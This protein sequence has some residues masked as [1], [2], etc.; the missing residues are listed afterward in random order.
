MQKTPYV[1]PILGGR[2]IEHLKQNIEALGLELSR[3][4][5]DE[6]NEAT[7]FDVGFPMNMIFMG[8]KYDVNLTSS[9]VA[10]LKTS[11][12]IDVPEKPKVSLST[13]L[14]L[15]CGLY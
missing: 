13:L 7:G 8:E 11:A 10:L 4:E 2:K 5:I 15:L 1:F 14:S 12:H 9:S 3:E 6:I